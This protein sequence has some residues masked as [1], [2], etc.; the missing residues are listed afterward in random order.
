MAYFQKRATGW[1]AYINRRGHKRVARTFSSLDDAKAWARS[2]ERKIDTGDFLPDR[3]GAKK[4]SFAQAAQDYED[5]VAPTKKGLQQAKSLIRRVTEVL[6]A[7]SLATITPQVIETYRDQRVQQV[8]RQTV[9][10]EV[11]MVSRIFGFAVKH[12]ALTGLVNPTRGLNFTPKQINNDRERRLSPLEQKYLT[13]A[14]HE[15]R[16][17]PWVAPVVAF[18]IET[19]AR[20]SEI[21]SLVWAD[22]DL[23][24]HVCRLRG[25]DGRETKNGAKFREVPL[26]A[27]AEAAILNLAPTMPHMRRGKVFGLTAS[28]LRQS[29][30]SCVKRARDLYLDDQLRANLPALRISDP[31]AEIRALRFKKR[32][33]NE[34]TVAEFESLKEHDATLVDLHFHDLRHEATSRLAR[35]FQMHEL[36]KITGHSS[37]GML[38][39]YYHPDIQSLAK[40]L[41]AAT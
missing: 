39:R 25:I 15:P 32:K 5:I 38:A 13:L 17:N 3:T 1:L 41:R 20:Q 27:A 21:I 40:R 35:H 29:W 33:P 11:G 4:V 14:L 37:A 22:V 36:M 28:A 24:R 2:I 9:K 8:S 34:A 23:E 18:A 6:G 16:R 30:A 26:S 7:R 19:A 12:Y 31:E 10:H